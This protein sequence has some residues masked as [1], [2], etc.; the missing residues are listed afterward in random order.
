MRLRWA[1]GLTSPGKPGAGP[2]FE[3][4]AIPL[5]KLTHNSA[6]AR[7]CF[8]VPILSLR[9]TWHCQLLSSVGSWETTFSHSF[10]PLQSAFPQISSWHLTLL[11]QTVFQETAS[12][13]DSR[14]TRD[15][16]AHLL[17][18]QGHCQWVAELD[19]VL[20]PLG[21]ILLLRA[22]PPTP[23]WGDFTEQP[24]TPDPEGGEG[25]GC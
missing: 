23:C 12:P 16:C 3:S 20:L 1:G 18:G 15:H 13:F 25:V 21:N 11:M 19:Q 24:D 17:I 9:S 5:A 14:S 6:S 22:A 4:S 10:P 2:I 8:P 7:G